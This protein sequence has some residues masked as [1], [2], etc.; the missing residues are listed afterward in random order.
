MPRES[1]KSTPPLLQPHERIAEV[2]FGL[3]MVLTFTGSLSVAEAGRHDVRMMLVG[4]L[5]CNLAWGIID[6]VFYLMGSLAEKG[7]GLKV[8][9]SVRAAPDAPTAH[10]LIVESLPSAVASVLTPAD[11]AS[12]YQR[13]QQ[14]PA[15]PDRARLNWADGRAALGV[16]S[17]VFFS[18]FPVALPFLFMAHA[19]PAMRVS[20]GIAMTMLFLAG[21]AYG[22]W[23]GQRP[24]VWGVSM[25]FL[26]GGLVALTMALGG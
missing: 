6:A 23:V 5:G 12:L 7:H 26:G 17:I 13:L 14:L 9:R 24:L 10:R 22:R 16:F 2:L 18:T 19:G 21:L 4:A 8:Y 3:I 11:L 1:V 20:N 15:P 25:V